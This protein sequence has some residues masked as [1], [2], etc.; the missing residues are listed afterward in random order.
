M[1]IFTPQ[2]LDSEFASKKQIASMNL[3][4]AIAVCIFGIGMLV[5]FVYYVYLLATQ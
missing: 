5:T 1:A 2:P 4:V 3:G